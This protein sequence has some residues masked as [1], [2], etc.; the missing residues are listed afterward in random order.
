MAYADYH[1]LIHIT[2]DMLSSMVKE[3]TGSYIIKYHPDPDNNPDQVL[4]IDFTPP[5]RRINMMEGLEKELGEPIPA[6]L[7]SKEAEVFF[8]QQCKK[9]KVD[10][11]KP[12]T[13]I[14]LID[15]LVGR[16]L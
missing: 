11:S 9:H 2:E 15:K 16:F 12:R 14:R 5:W 13:T 8:D 7:E 6:D 4:N 1:D 10:C 3:I